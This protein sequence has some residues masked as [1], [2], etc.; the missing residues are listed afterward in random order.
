MNHI[1]TPEFIGG[2]QSR[3]HIARLVNKFCYDE[4]NEA[5]GTMNGIG[6]EES[7]LSGSSL[8]IFCGN[9]EGQRI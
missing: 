8:P 7:F 6:N 4:N 5:K 1:K 2:V 9:K 3:L